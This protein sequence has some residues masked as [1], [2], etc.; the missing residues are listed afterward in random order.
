MPVAQAV[1]QA[2]CVGRG[3]RSSFEN[4]AECGPPCQGGFAGSPRSPLSN[5]AAR[6]A[7][8]TLCRVE[9]AAFA[10]RR[11]HPLD[12]F[13]VG[14]RGLGGHQPATGIVLHA[15]HIR[16]LDPFD[17]VP[18]NGPTPKVHG[19][20]VQAEHQRG[21]A[22]GHQALEV[23]RGGPKLRQASEQNLTSDQF[24]AR[25]LRQVNPPANH[26]RLAGQVLFN[27]LCS[28]HL[29][30]A[31]QRAVTVLTRSPNALAVAMSPGTISSG[32]ESEGD[33]VIK[34]A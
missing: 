12:V 32:E 21:Q 23:V 19:F 9:P 22:G 14:N 26:A 27:C 8:A 10:L 17:R 31:A 33:A 5:A 16:Q 25:L 18:S 15:Q 2:F 34:P 6:S 11:A 28:S 4:G 13:V 1:S 30:Q 20:R 7:I 29:D 24:M 3:P